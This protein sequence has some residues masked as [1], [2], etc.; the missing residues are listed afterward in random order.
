MGVFVITTDNWHWK[1]TLATGKAEWV[2]KMEKD[3]KTAVD[4][5]KRCGAK[6]VTVVPGNL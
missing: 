6:W 3:C 1:T 5:A 2:E 4:V